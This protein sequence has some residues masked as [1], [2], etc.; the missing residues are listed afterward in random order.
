VH[1][2][3]SS[4]RITVYA[5]CIMCFYQNFVLVAEYHID[6][7]QTLQWRLQLRISGATNCWQK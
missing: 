3:N 4:M 5:E 2:V 6:C 7:W 1:D